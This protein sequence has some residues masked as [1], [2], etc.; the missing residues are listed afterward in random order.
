M[1]QDPIK[2]QLQFLKLLGSP[3]DDIRRYNFAVNLARHNIRVRQN[4]ENIAYIERRIAR[5]E[6]LGVQ[7]SDRVPS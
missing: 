3:R 5:R 4:R 1:I 6:Q 2:H 7:Q